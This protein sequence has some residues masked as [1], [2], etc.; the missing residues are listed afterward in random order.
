MADDFNPDDINNEE[1]AHGNRDNT[2]DEAA[3]LM[4]D[5]EGDQFGTTDPQEAVERGIPYEPPDH[6]T[7]DDSSREDR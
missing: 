4:E 3:H 1:P 6:S 5:V 7:Q 2:S